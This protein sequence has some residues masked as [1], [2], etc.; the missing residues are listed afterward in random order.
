MDLN[1]AVFDQ[2]DFDEALANDPD[3]IKAKLE[4]AEKACEHW[5]SIYPVEHDER[6]TPPRP[7]GTGRD[8]IHVRHNGSS[9]SVVCGDE[10]AAV[11]EY[12]SV[13]GVPEFACRART[14]EY[15]NNGGGQKT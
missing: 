10:I 12:G 7:P 5:R 8:S 2:K 3:A 6:K 15:F 14:Q 4:L 11:L 13:N 1:D 9:V